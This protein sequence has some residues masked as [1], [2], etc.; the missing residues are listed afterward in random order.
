MKGQRKFVYVIIYKL[1]NW[2]FWKLKNE[3]VECEF[4]R[5]RIFV[6]F[7]DVFLEIWGEGVWS[8]MGF[9]YIFVR[10]RNVWILRNRC[11][12]ENVFQ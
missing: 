5:E 7:V 11:K 10:W 3:I 2:F 12:L 9:Q 6:L 1:M 4:W 8:I